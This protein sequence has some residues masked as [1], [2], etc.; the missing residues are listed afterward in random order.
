MPLPEGV[1]FAL[2]NSLS[3]IQYSIIVQ[4]VDWG[5]REGQDPPLQSTI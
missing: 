5:I 2:L 4:R 1:S 3:L